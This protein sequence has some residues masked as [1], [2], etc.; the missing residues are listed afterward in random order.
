M[1]SV[2]LVFASAK[3]DTSCQ[4]T[5]FFVPITNNETHITIGRF[6]ELN[7]SKH[8]C[9]GKSCNGLIVNKRAVSPMIRLT[10]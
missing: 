10:V 1:G 7:S 5:P 3:I 9:S 2:R 8:K 4:K 6:N